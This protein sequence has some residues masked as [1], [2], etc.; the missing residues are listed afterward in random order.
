MSMLVAIAALLLI[1]STAGFTARP[2]S[3]NRGLCRAQQTVP[4]VHYIAKKT[5]ADANDDAA[6][7]SKGVM[8]IFKKSPSTLVVIPFV[9][10]FGLDLILNIAVV[11]KS[12]LHRRVHCLDSVAINN[13]FD[14]RDEGTF[15]STR[16]DND[17][18]I[19]HEAYERD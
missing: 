15:C 5:N 3:W 19:N 1:S 9:A 2:L 8:G 18:M 11:T 6:Q 13:V 12:P 10:L 17:R 4:T 14:E 16:V 7:E